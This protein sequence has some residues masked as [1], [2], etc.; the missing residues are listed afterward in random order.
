M[1][2]QDLEIK[3][4]GRFVFL[5]FLGFFALIMIVNGI[6]AT[7]AIKTHSGVVTANAYERGL[8]YN[9][10]IAAAHEQDML[11]WSGDMT[12]DSNTLTYS[13]RGHDGAPVS[14]AKVMLELTRPVA[15]GL[16]FNLTLVESARGDYSST[17]TFP[18]PGQWQARAFVKWQDKQF[19]SSKTLM[20][21]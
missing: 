5:L 21:R 6:F 11:G 13:L 8:T 12:L 20:A 10:I 16:D 14:G 4:S 2:P 1:T 18:A 7:L 9:R 19:Q 17:I 3:K 15:P